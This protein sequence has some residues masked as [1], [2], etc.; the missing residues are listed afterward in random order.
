M[1]TAPE[2]APLIEVR[3]IVKHFGSV[4]ALSGVSLKVSAGEVL[5]LLGDFA[6]SP[7]TATI[8]NFRDEY[9]EHIRSGR[10]FNGTWSPPE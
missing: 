8:R 7:V 1:T 4:I 5:C 3:D 9:V 2:Q 10:S 6:T